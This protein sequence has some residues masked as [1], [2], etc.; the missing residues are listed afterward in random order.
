[1]LAMCHIE[2]IGDIIES[3]EIDLR[4]MIEQV[5]VPKTQSILID[6]QKQAP[7]KP[8]GPNPIMGLMMESDVLKKRLAK[9]EPESGVASQRVVTASAEANPAAAK[10]K[11]SK[12]TQ[13]PPNPLMGAVM[14]SD[15]LKKKLAQRRVDD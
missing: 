9:A 14:N 6:I 11:A 1:M 5:H 10:P 4:S 8:Q 2:N 15:V 7:K 12:K 13:L 3:N